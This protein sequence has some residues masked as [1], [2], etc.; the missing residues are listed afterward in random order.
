MHVWILRWVEE[1][2]KIKKV[3]LNNEVFPSRAGQ[4]IAKNICLSE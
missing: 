2:W 1:V 3:L 4:E